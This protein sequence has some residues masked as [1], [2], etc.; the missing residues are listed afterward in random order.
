MGAW[1][2]QA[3][4]EGRQAAFT[5]LLDQLEAKRGERVAALSSPAIQTDFG[6]VSPEAM[7]DDVISQI[8]RLAAVQN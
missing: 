2:V 6:W 7:L 5:Q 8:R 3:R 4:E 1:V